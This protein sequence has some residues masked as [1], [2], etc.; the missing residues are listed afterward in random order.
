MNS[1]NNKTSD[2]HG[3]LLNLTH[4]ANLKRTDKNAALSIL[5][6]YY[7]WRNIK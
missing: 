2:P 4:K 3:L 7:A 6:I 1:R 5:S